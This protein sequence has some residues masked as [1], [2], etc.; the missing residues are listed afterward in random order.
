MAWHVNLHGDHQV[1]TTTVAT[2]RES[3]A[4]DS[5]LLT[6]LSHWTVVLH[7]DR[8]SIQVVEDFIETEQCLL[9]GRIPL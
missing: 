5:D 8:F 9:Q 3:L 2:V 6:V 4:S 1:T 7:L